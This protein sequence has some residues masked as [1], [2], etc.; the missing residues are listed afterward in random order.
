MEAARAAKDQ[1]VIDGEDAVV[2]HGADTGDERHAREGVG[3]AWARSGNPMDRELVR[4]LEYEQLVLMRREPRDAIAVAGVNVDRPGITGA[5]PILGIQRAG[6]IEPA[7]LRGHT[8][9][10]DRVFGGGDKGEVRRGAG[11][12]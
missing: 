8:G 4:P 5:S 1:I 11:G 7:R 3:P 12:M 2:V 6:V 9:G 10:P